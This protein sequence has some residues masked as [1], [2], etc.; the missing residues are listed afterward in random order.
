MPVAKLSPMSQAMISIT[1]WMP[2][3][4]MPESTASPVK[5]RMPSQVV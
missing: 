3:V 5:W 2:N 4:I 1:P